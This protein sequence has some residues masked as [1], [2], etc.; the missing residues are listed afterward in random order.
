MIE[1][2]ICLVI[3]FNKTTDAMSV[4]DYCL[5]NAVGGR[6]IP[7]PKEISAGCGLAWKCEVDKKNEMTKVLETLNIKCDKMVELVI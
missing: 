6:L 2:K 7:L 5:K 1:K 3:S 4:E